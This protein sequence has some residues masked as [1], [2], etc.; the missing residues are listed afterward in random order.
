M[1]PRDRRRDE[2]SA[3]DRE[4]KLERLRRAL[5][6]LSERGTCD[7]CLVVGR[8]LEG[9][10]IKELAEAEG[11]T[12]RAVSCRLSRACAWLKARILEGQDEV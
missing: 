9:R 6:E 12:V 1:E 5:R 2:P 4:A 3:T 10:S 7:Y 8:H 11:L